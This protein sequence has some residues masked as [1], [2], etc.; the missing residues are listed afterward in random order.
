M[1]LVIKIV[2]NNKKNF[3][4]HF[5][6]ILEELIIFNGCK[7]KD[8]IMS[9]QSLTKMIIFKCLKIFNQGK[10]SFMMKIKKK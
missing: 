10:I 5:L 6:K 9:K 3:M 8:K 7:I 2:H 4:I 1:Y